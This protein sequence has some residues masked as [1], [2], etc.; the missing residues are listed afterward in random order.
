MTAPQF[1]LYV[2]AVEGRLVTRIGIGS[3]GAMSYIGAE[4]DHAD[5]STIRWDT[6]AIV[7]ITQR[8][9]A[10]YGRDYA[11]EIADGGLVK[12]TAAEYEAQQ[13]PKTTNPKKAPQSVGKDE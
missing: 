6:T 7:G 4:R 1:G 9:L 5:P 3:P 2:S 8:E 13:A 11:R 12:R 10:R